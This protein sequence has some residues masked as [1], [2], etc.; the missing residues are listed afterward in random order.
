MFWVRDYFHIIRQL[1]S[2]FTNLFTVAVNVY[3]LQFVTLILLIYLSCIN[4][5]CDALAL[6]KIYITYK[7]K[8]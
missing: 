2:T 6:F 4:V 8:Y 3:I 1:F 7:Y 5:K